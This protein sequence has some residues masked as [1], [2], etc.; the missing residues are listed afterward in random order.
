MNYWNFL[1]KKDIKPVETYVFCRLNIEEEEEETSN[2]TSKRTDNHL[3]RVN[4]TRSILN[5]HQLHL[6]NY[7]TSKHY[8]ARDKNE[9]I[10]QEPTFQALDD[11]IALQQAS[12]DNAQKLRLGNVINNAKQQ[13][14][15]YYLVGSEENSKGNS[16]FQ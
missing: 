1:G 8:T 9:L 11:F 4:S 13:L 14:K 3:P 2:L 12:A 10:A 15:L 7:I 6:N 16:N 5:L